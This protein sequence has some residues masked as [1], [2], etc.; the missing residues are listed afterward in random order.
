MQADRK[1]KFIT[2]NSIKSKTV[3]I[4][5]E[6]IENKRCEVQRQKQSVAQTE[7]EKTI[8]RNACPKR[9]FRQALT[10]SSTG[11]IAEFKRKSPS[12]GWISKDADAAAIVAAY[13]S[14]GAA[15]VSVL[16]D[17]SYFGGSFEDFAAARLSA[18]LP[19]LRKDFIVD[20]Y[21]IYQAKAMRAD[22]ILLIAA[23]LT[24]AQTAQYSALARELDME[25]LL[26]IH[27]ETELDH[28]CP[29]VDVAGINNRNLSTFVTDV[30][31]SFELGA[32]IPSGYIKI[33]ESGLSEAST[34]N[35]L[36][37]AGFRGFLMGEAFMKTSDPGKALRQF[38]EETV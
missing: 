21:Q 7:L 25:T 6:I 14:A 5:H 17:E 18:D 3:N 33:S 24:P 36:R 31:H 27:D 9:S 23:A 1:D 29:T 19:I 11:I 15:A 13:K 34:V 37:R 32:K 28:I 38:I 20:P 22:I 8:A 4:L 2:R 30:R 35:E 16:T 26:E 12:K 10:G